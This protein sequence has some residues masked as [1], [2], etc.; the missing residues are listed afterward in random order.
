MIFY[1]FYHDDK[2]PF[3]N[4]EKREP[5]DNLLYSMLDVNRLNG[6]DTSKSSSAD[7]KTAA[8]LTPAVALEV[9]FDLAPASS[10]HQQ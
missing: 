9:P 2:C 5:N 10:W 4:F 6:R 7:L 3:L 1:Q 8:M